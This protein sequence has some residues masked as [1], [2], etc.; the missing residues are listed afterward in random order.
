VSLDTLLTER[1]TEEAFAARMIIGDNRD[2]VEN[3]NY[4]SEKLSLLSSFLSP[5]LFSPPFSHRSDNVTLTD[6][7][8]FF[9][10]FI[11]DSPASLYSLQVLSRGRD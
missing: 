2:N 1:D 11:G 5:S 10:F 9:F 7:F 8:S 6:P 4:D 3:C